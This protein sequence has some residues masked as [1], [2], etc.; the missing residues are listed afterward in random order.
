[1]SI[2]ESSWVNKFQGHGLLSWTFVSISC[3]LLSKLR[4]SIYYSWIYVDTLKTW[5]EFY[6]PIHMGQCSPWYHSLKILSIIASSL[7][8]WTLFTIFLS[9]I[10]PPCII[11]TNIDF[12]YFQS[13]Y[14][15]L[16]DSGGPY[17]MLNMNET[18]PCN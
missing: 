14:S 3:G 6:S 4:I 5:V 9:S 10:L 17:H 12:F 8:I 13:F 1:M 11:C 15:R 18:Q 16:Q 2:I 7:K